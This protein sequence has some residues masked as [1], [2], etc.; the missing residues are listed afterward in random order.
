VG[1]SVGD[2]M[3]IW[4]GNSLTLRYKKA[5]VQYEHQVAL[6]QAFSDTAVHAQLIEGDELLHIEFDKND[7]S[8]SG[9][10]D[11]KV[12]TFETVPNSVV[13]VDSI[14][15]DMKQSRADLTVT[16]RASRSTEAVNAVYANG[17][18]GA[19]SA[20]RARRGGREREQGDENGVEAVGDYPSRKE[21][22]DGGHQKSLP[23]RLIRAFNFLCAT[24]IEASRKGDP[25]DSSLRSRR[26]TPASVRRADVA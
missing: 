1:G 14:E 26:A 18:R 7:G 9:V 4:L 21:L 13:S 3:L 8:T 6:P 10:V 12:C 19:R 22:P 25:T 5:D 15:V 11:G 23:G 17:A 24:V 16:L 20:H 2:M